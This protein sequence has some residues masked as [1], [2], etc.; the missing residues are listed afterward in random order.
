MAL[1]IRSLFSMVLNDR[2]SEWV[3]LL[4]LLLLLRELDSRLNLWV[5]S[6][7]CLLLISFGV[8]FGDCDSL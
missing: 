6:R 2:P 3:S 7:R 5:L 8:E 4:L 1:V